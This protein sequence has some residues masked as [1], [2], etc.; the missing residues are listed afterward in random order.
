[1]K[2]F[3]II[4]NSYQGQLKEVLKILKYIN[5]ISLN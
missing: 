2:R 4:A 3:A 1:M 5:S